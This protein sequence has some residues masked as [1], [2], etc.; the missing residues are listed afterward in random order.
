MISL[1]FLAQHPPERLFQEAAPTAHIDA[2]CQRSAFFFLRLRSPPFQNSDKCEAAQPVLVR[3]QLKSVTESVMSHSVEV[4]LQSL[5]AD[6]AADEAAD[7]LADEAADEAAD[8]REK[9]NA[10]G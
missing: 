10:S 4:E 8:E 2:P 6:E 9:E 5:S 7:E 3:A 1:P